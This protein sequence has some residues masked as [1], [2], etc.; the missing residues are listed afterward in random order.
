M[1]PT[2]VLLLI[3]TCLC[4]SVTFAASEKHASWSYHGNDG[5][6]LWGSLDKSYSL[7]QEGSQQSPVDISNVSD[8]LMYPLS[9]FYQTN[10]VQL[11][12][13][14]H[15]LQNNFASSTKGKALTIGEYSHKNLMVT[16]NW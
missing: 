13:N 11:I 16:G 15:T 6:K 4:I 5:P 1:R 14:G 7:C 2:K 8:S 10:S 12:N 9:F 3:F